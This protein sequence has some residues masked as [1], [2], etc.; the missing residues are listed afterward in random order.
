VFD[1]GI[2]GN[3]CT[4]YSFE[5]EDLVLEYS[6]S[7]NCNIQIWSPSVE[8]AGELILTVHTTP[9]E[10]CDL[11]DEA[12]C[13]AIEGCNWNTDHGGECKNTGWWVD[14]SSNVD[15]SYIEFD[16]D[17]Q[18]SECHFEI[19]GFENGALGEAGFNIQ[20][21][22]NEPNDGDSTIYENRIIATATNNPL[23]VGSGKLGSGGHSSSG[24]NELCVDNIIATDNNG[25][26]L[27]T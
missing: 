17:A 2:F 6:D 25:M 1:S 4:E 22:H 14:Y 18:M 7:S 19:R 8:G 9:E 20:I 11:T 26:E 24:G 27:S 23:P 12:E 3:D 5:D 10:T 15:I 21:I 13:E 16:L